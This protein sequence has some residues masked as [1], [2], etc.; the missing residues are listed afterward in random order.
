M[1]AEQMTELTPGEIAALVAVYRA[2]QEREK[3]GA[4]GVGF[5]LVQHDGWCPKAAGSGAARCLCNPT[6]KM[7][8]EQE[9][10]QSMRNTANRAQRR[11]AARKAKK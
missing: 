2:Q 3:S 1:K 9:F 7:V 10:A 11:A 4:E 6:T 5:M 8:G